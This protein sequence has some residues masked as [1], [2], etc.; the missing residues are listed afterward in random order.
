MIQDS[1]VSEKFELSLKKEVTTNRLKRDLLE[2]LKKAFSIQWTGTPWEA[3]CVE[4]QMI[5]NNEMCMGIVAYK[6]GRFLV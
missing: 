2:K 6:K 3:F 4:K 1:P 5:L